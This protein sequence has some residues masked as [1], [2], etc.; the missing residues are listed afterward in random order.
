MPCNKAVSITK[1]VISQKQLAGLVTP[2]VMESLMRVLAS[3]HSLTEQAAAWTSQDRNLT[4]F[5]LLRDVAGAG[6][7]RYG[8]QRESGAV[9]LRVGGDWGL[10]LIAHADGR[11]ELS[12]T[13]Y[14]QGAFGQ[15]LLD[16]L[17]ELAGGMAQLLLATQ[18]EQALA[19]F[20]TVTSEQITVDNAGVQQTAI[21]LTLRV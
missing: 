13:D 6:G 12:T 19:A 15:Q 10:D 4:Y 20:G 5:T 17:T 18:V 8:A 2:D 9:T 3:Q 21:K 1:A 16:E 14:S 7:S 11:V